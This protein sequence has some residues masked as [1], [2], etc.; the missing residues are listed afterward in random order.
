[1]KFQGN[2][3]RPLLIQVKLFSGQTDLLGV[4]DS[5]SKKEGFAF[6]KEEWMHFSFKKKEEKLK[7]LLKTKQEEEIRELEERE[8][9]RIE[10]KE[11]ERKIHAKT[12]SDKMIKLWVEKFLPNVYDVGSMK[13][14]FGAWKEDFL[15]CVFTNREEEW[16]K[17]DEE[18]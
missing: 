16:Q 2:S 5:A 3:H 7:Q 1:V 10:E 15:H 13:E 17:Q 18:K 14:G 9:K 11:K 12:R 8:Q 4:H 6:W